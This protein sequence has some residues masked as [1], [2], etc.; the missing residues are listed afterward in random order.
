GATLAEYLGWLARETGWRVVYEDPSLAALAGTI[1]LHGTI[2]GMVPDESASVV[3]PG[4]G[5][6]WDLEGGT[7]RL[8]R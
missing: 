6:A 3:L 2:A 1:R 4:S 7:L 8:R 5:L